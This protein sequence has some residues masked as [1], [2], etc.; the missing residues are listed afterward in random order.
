MALN[1]RI[2]IRGGHEK[3]PDAEASFPLTVTSIEDLEHGLRD[4]LFDWKRSRLT[5][6]LLRDGGTILIEITK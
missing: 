1:C 3:S 5:D 4:A 2:S 6:D